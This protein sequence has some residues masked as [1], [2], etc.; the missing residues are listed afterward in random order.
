MKNLKD[1]CMSSLEMEKYNPDSKIINYKDLLNYN[2]LIN[3]IKTNKKIIIFYPISADNMGHWTCLLVKK[4]DI[5]FFDSYGLYFDEQQVY[6]NKDILKS[7]KLND[8]YLTMLLFD[9]FEKG[10]RIFRNPYKLQSPK[11]QTCGRY[12]SLFLI[13]NKSPT[14]FYEKFFKYNYEKPDDVIIK[15]IK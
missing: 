7:N 2:S 14:E 4:K 10:Y 1:I 5:Y 12:V 8:E 9:L 13:Y 15:Y 3:L 11:S 6:A